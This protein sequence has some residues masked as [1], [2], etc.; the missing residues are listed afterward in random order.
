MEVYRMEKIKNIIYCLV[1]IVIIAL[2]VNSGID[3]MIQELDNIA[4]YNQEY[5]N[6]MF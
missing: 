5:Y 3:A 2:M 4:A 6:K 1:A